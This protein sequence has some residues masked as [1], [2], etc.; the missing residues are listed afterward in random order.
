MACLGLELVQLTAEPYMQ[1]PLG[2]SPL[3]VLC[4]PAQSGCVQGLLAA[5]RC[6]WRAA[7]QQERLFFEQECPGF[8]SHVCSCEIP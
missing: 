6:A 2:L 7:D 3:D 1:L 4:R 5:E 8:G